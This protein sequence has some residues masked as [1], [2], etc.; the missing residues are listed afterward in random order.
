MS[1]AFH[2]NTLKISK[3]LELS[4]YCHLVYNNG[5][6]WGFAFSVLPC[7]GAEQLVMWCNKITSDS[8]R[9]KGD[10]GDA[11]RPK[12]ERSRNI[13]F[14][15]VKVLSKRINTNYAARFTTSAMRQYGSLYKERITT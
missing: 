3:M 4:Q 13:F 6:V 12:H 7:D 1:A 10:G 8:V 15:S 14:F 11:N 5:I 2:L 9:G